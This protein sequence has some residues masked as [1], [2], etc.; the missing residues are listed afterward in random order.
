MGTNG[1]YTKIK[2]KDRERERERKRKRKMKEKDREREFPRRQMRLRRD[3]L[4]EEKNEIKRE[5]AFLWF[6]FLNLNE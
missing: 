6:H 4:E 5:S 3:C 1:K 2:K